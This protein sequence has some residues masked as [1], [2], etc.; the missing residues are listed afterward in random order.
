[1]WAPGIR[2][3]LTRKQTVAVKKKKGRKKREKRKLSDRVARTTRSF[4]KRR[5]KASREPG[6]DHPDH[7]TPGQ[8][9]DGENTKKE[10]S[11]RVAAATTKAGCWIKTL[12]ECG[13]FL[14]RRG[15]KKVT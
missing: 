6:I 12:P 15:E 11:E 4:L 8:R 9:N 1:M 3:E 13:H 14:Y 10:K 5:K 2:E 7:T